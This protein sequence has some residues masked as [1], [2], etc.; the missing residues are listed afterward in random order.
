M[1][2][3]NGFDDAPG[4]I[5]QQAAGAAFAVPLQVL[6]GPVAR[7]DGAVVVARLNFTALLAASN[8]TGSVA[9]ASVLA[10]ENG[11][12]VRYQ[13]DPVAD[14]DAAHNAAGELVLLLSGPTDAGT[15]RALTVTF[16]A[17]GAANPTLQKVNLTDDCDDEGEACLQIATAAQTWKYQLLGGGFSSL[18]GPDG[19]NWISYKPSGGSNGSYRGVPNLYNGKDKAGAP[20]CLHP[21]DSNTRTRLLRDGPLRVS[22]E[23]AVVNRT[24]NH[25]GDWRVRVD[26]Y[27][28]H[29]TVTVEETPEPAPGYVSPRRRAPFIESSF[30]CVLLATA[31]H[32]LSPSEGAVLRGGHDWQ[33]FM[34]EDTPHGA[35]SPATQYMYLPN[36]TKLPLS[37]RWDTA[38]GEDCHAH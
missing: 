22:L 24:L 5:E 6:A 1:F 32:I 31:C 20:C 34:Y 38:L 9:A 35:I 33:W 10:F 8:C 7:L 4:T 26:V 17:E 37:Q 15:S 27:P 19:A 18:L 12:T 29:A 11:E 28:A 2:V 3:Q 13:F 25:T 23:S 14:F 16:G 30:T 36:G 21:G